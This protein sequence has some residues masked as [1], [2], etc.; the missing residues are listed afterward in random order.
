MKHKTD[1]NYIQ[2]IFIKYAKVESNSMEDAK[3]VPSTETQFEMGKIVMNDCNAMGITDVEQDKNGYVVARIK[4]NTN[5]PTIA[6]IAHLDTYPGTNG[7]NVMPIVHKNYDGNDIKLP[8]DGTVI[9]VADF[10]E[11]KTQKGKTLITSSGDT[12][13]GGD[14]KAGIAA[15]METGKFLMENKDFKHGD[16]CLVFTPDEEIGHGAELLDI[17]KLNAVGGYT[18]D[19]EGFGTITNETF[20]ANHLTV[21]IKGRDIHPGYAKDKMVNAIRVASTF[22]SKLPMEARP[23]TTEK[24]LGFLHPISMNGDV[25]SMKIGMLVRDF[26][27]E[28]LEKFQAIAKKVA[29]ETMREHQGSEIH[30]EI[31]EQYRNM[32]YELDKDKRIVDYAWKAM[33]NCGYKPEM[34]QARGGTDGSKLSYRGLLTP[35]LPVGF[36]AFHSK[37]EW[38]CLEE[39]VQCADLLKELV[40]VWAK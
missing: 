14:D 30:L 8:K 10:P 11:L 9:T 12:L 19:S 17:K 23:E 24:R 38:V 37:T 27:V 1:V 5:A 4:G 2:D 40:S 15:I 26:T 29:D 34:G 39:M 16:V 32:K 36:Y 22:I 28:G 7:K 3:K 6:L 18:I 25:S 31:K 13:L 21:N 33:E 20:C 35:D